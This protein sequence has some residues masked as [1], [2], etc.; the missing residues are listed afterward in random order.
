MF[1]ATAIMVT[2]DQLP[3]AARLWFREPRWESLKRLL[4][5]AH[6]IHDKEGLIWL[7]TSI[8][9]RL[10]CLDGANA[11]LRAARYAGGAT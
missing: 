6:G 1:G 7:G 5:L 3:D 11:V 8:E 10:R 9:T 4:V 2:G